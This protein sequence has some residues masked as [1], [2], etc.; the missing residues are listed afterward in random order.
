M[1]GSELYTLINN[2][3]QILVLPL[4]IL[5]LAL[6][7]KSSISRLFERFQNVE[8]KMGSFSFKV[9]L[10]KY[11]Q[12]AVK[13]AVALEKEGESD[14]AEAIVKDASN[15]VAEL[16]GLSNSDVRYLIE[17]AEGKPPSGRWGKVHLV[18][19]GLV[20]LDGG[21][22]TSHGKSFVERYLRAQRT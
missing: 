8:G 9:S 17:L 14:Q 16:Y 20:E 18:R 5:I 12:D 1:T 4:T 10:E 21:H 6:V 15:F 13:K 3:L 2:T 22:I 19:A 11:M 7:F